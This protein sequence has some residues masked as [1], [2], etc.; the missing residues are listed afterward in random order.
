MAYAPSAYTA[1]ELAARVAATTGLSAT[2]DATIIYQALTDAGEACATLPGEDWWWLHTNSSFSTVEDTAYYGL[3]TVNTTAMAALSNVERVYYDDDWELPELDWKVY[4]EWYRLVRPTGSTAQPLA[5]ALT[6][7]APVM[8]LQPIP[9][10]VYTIY[11][12]YKRRHGKLTS[13]SAAGDII[14][15]GDYHAGIYVAG[16]AWILR[17]SIGDIADVLQC[18]QFKSAVDR[19]RANAPGPRDINPANMFADSKPGSLPHNRRV[20][21]TSDGYLIQD[22]PSI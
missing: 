17:H 5:Y 16:A 12:D 10:A 9:D 18:P 3:R 6:G 11:V 4:Q 21:A 2:T 14:I 15:P 22:T 1:A 20:V 8:W 13:S 7:E 19:M